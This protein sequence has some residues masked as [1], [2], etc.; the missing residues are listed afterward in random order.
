MKIYSY[1]NHIFDKNIID[2]LIYTSKNNIQNKDDFY[3]LINFTS[4]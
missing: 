3:I 1:D 2:N 4:L